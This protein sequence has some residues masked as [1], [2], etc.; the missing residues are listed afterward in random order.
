MSFLILGERK[1]AKDPNE[2]NNIK[3][4]KDVMKNP[5]VYDAA[6]M[7]FDFGSATKL[8]AS[9]STKIAEGLSGLLTGPLWIMCLEP[10]IATC[11]TTVE[12]LMLEYHVVPDAATNTLTLVGEHQVCNYFTVDVRLTEM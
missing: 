5:I 10:D 12:S 1:L 3:Q 8:I 11:S 9:M 6:A 2:C 7:P 4:D